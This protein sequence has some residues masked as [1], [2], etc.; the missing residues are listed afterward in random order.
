M[1]N[2]RMIT[3]KRTHDASNAIVEGG[4][5]RETLHALFKESKHLLLTNTFNFLIIFIFVKRL[6]CSSD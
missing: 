1:K 6:N 4:V 3:R 2:T 5:C